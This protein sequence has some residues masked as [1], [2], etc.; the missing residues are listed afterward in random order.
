M[1][2]TLKATCSTVHLGGFSQELEPALVVNSGDRIAVETYTGFALCPE[3][4]PTFV[5]PQLWDI[6][7]HLPPEQKIASGPHL[8]TG[9]IYVRDAEPGD[10]IVVE[11]EAV[12]PRLPVGFNLIRPGWGA[13]PQ[14]FD[15]RRLRFIPLDLERGVAEFPPNSGIFIPLEPFFGI[16]GVATPEKRS[17]IPPGI[18]GGN[19]DNRHLRP[20]SRLYLPVFVPGALVSIGDGHAAQGDGEVNVT[21]IETSMNGT[22]TL[23]LRKDLAIATPLIETPTHWITLGF[24]DT[25][26]TAL[27]SA[28]SQAI[29]LLERGVGIGAEEAYV[30][31]SLAV[32]FHVA[33][34]VNQPQKCVHGMLSK[35]MLPETDRAFIGAR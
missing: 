34:A 1:N 27:E 24:G 14:R 12:S 5:T 19:L 7:H 28:L 4:P 29:A 20:R 23:N 33:Q 9:P 21:A 16:I 35:T 3:A 31:C 6:Y 10:A 22:F 17:S 30:L 8:L 26:D 25:L 15:K 32:H 18:Y 13:L 11:I 2:H